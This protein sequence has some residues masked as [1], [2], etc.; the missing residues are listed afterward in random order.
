MALEWD[1]I[2]LSNNPTTGFPR[3]VLQQADIGTGK[4]RVYGSS[5]L[6]TIECTSSFASQ[7]Y[8]IWLRKKNRYLFEEYIYKKS[9]F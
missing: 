1:S 4:G 5:V 8:N 2:S 6:L 3:H 7:T 9:I